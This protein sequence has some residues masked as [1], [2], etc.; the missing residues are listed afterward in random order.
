[1]MESNSNEH[2]RDVKHMYHLRS[3]A[4]LKLSYPT[5]YYKYHV[6]QGDLIQVRYQ[7][8]STQCTNYP[9]FVNLC[10][11]ILIEMRVLVI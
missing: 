3:D 4:R 6:P 5:I 8:Y 1:M 11:W 2:A 9:I 7:V 10:I